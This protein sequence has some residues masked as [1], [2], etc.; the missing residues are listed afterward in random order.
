LSSLPSTSVYRQA[1]EALTNHRLK[2]VETSG[3]DVA[4]FESALGSMAE[5]ILEEAKSEQ[6][7]VGKMV[8]WKG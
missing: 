7:L 4:K 2:T 1:T 5:V 3:E 6:M 8:E